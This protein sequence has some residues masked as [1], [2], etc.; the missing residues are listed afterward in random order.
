MG[1]FNF[2]QMGHFNFAVT[3]FKKYIDFIVNNSIM[4]I[5]KPI[6]KLHTNKIPMYSNE[7]IE[8]GVMKFPLRESIGIII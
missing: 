8:N 4:P 1:H 3:R 5:Y 2:A 7:E 6:R